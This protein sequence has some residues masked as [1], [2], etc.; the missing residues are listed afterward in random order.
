[1]Q[2][3]LSLPATDQ[4]MA[5]PPVNFDTIVEKAVVTLTA[6]LKKDVLA[7]A[8]SSGKD[9]TA[10]LI[11]TLIALERLKTQG[12]E[13]AGPTFVQHGSTGVENPAIESLAKVMMSSLM[14]WAGER[15]HDIR[16]KISE[17]RLASSWVVSIIGGSALPTY[18]NS[19]F[20]QCSSNMKIT[21]A[22]RTNKIIETEIASLSTT[23]LRLVTVLGTRYDESQARAA[24]MAK[25]N[26]SDTTVQEYDSRHIIAPIANWSQDDVWEL[27]GVAGLNIGEYPVW[28][29]NFSATVETYRD[30]LSGECPVVAVAEKMGRSGCGARF[31]CSVCVAV[32]TDKSMAAMA[33]D[34]KSAH[35]RRLLHN[36]DFLSSIQGDYDRRSW[37]TRQIQESGNDL[38]VKIQPDGFNS[39]TLLDIAGSYLLADREEYERAAAFESAWKEGRLPDDAYL[40]KRVAA[41]LGPDLDYIERMREPQFRTI[42]TEKLVAADFYNAVLRRHPKP[43]MLLELAHKIWEEGYSPELPEIRQFPPHA[44]PAGRWLTL[45]DKDQTFP[46]LGEPLTFAFAGEQCFDPEEMHASSAVESYIARPSESFDV[47]PEAAALIVSLLY[48]AEWRARHHQTNTNVTTA[49][50][51]YLALG[52]VS[53]SSQGRHRLHRIMAVRQRVESLGLYDM[54]HPELLDMCCPNDPAK[55]QAF[56]QELIF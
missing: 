21:P 1:M 36:R 52:A 46:G 53:L 22:T 19:R 23:P 9:S 54:P 2:T 55:K 10:C 26:E 42:T 8:W 25:R 29:D 27:L 28:R 37:V 39:A 41:G 31:G 38:Q 7:V 11:L 44:A 13:P 50:Q 5:P 49:V 24:N 40:K 48:P 12:I 6:L 33:A 15:A 34:D 56:Q 47:D 17:P 18:A 35:L 30:A 4:W 20:R 16:I 43:Y 45:G 14:K 3:T 51:T 32:K